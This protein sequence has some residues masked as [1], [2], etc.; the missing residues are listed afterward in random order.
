[1]KRKEKAQA[2]TGFSW[3]TV[4]PKGNW[5]EITMVLD[6]SCCWRKT[7]TPLY[8][9][10]STAQPWHQWNH[11]SL[12][13][14]NN[15]IFNSSSSTTCCSRAKVGSQSSHRF[16]FSFQQ[17]H[18]VHLSVTPKSHHYSLPICYM[19]KPKNKQTNNR[20]KNIVLKHTHT[21][22]SFLPILY[23]L[24]KQ[25]IAWNWCNENGVLF[26]RS[27]TK[28]YLWSQSHTWQ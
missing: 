19:Q 14:S 1:M 17:C 6:S 22:T 28:T 2:A 12:S 18:L 10:S 26:I 11:Q 27:V 23:N 15:L 21:K 20:R 16:D 13:L 25:S 7:N 4:V 5:K 3:S 8:P 9:I 24:S